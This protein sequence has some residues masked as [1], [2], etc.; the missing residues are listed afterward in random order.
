MTTRR[1]AR[2][3]VFGLA[4]AALVAAFVSVEVW[5]D[6]VYGEPAPGDSVLYIRSGEAVRR[7]SLSFTP[8]VAD[9]ARS[10]PYRSL[11]QHAAEDLVLP[12][13]RF[14]VPA[15]RTSPRRSIPGSRSVPV[16]PDF[17]AEGYRAVLGARPRS[18]CSRRGSGQT[19][20]LALPA[21][22]RFRPL[23]WL[24]DYRA[25]A[26]W[27]QKAA[28]IPGAP[29]WLRSLAAVTLAQ[30]G[31]RRSSRALW[32]SLR[33]SADN[34]WLR[35]NATFRLAQ[36]DALDAI[37]QLT[38]IA[39]AYRAR[40]GEFPP[41]WDVLVRARLLSAMPVDPGAGVRAGRGERRGDARPGFTPPPAAGWRAGCRRPACNEHGLPRRRAR[42][43]RHRRFL[44]V[45]IYRMPRDLSVVWPA[46][47]CTACGR[48][49]AGTRTSRS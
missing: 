5:R 25:A 23:W 37:D 34:E 17:L 28:D 38:A 44:N 20:A 19:D 48:E 46:S 30:G 42:R 32:Q 18:R 40:T 24:G 12:E 1:G 11:R 6:R 15:A 45:C 9:T 39:A 8:L 27:F 3:I 33:E 13:L 10:A 49:I 47:R 21:G 2:P 35:N 31:D 22:H 29:W 43:P 16:R 4:M 14:S 26:V 41:S 36:L 7:M